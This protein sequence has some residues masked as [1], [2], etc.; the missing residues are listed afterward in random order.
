M[1]EEEV[2][3]VALDEGQVGRRFGRLRGRRGPWHSKGAEYGEGR[4]KVG[5]RSPALPAL[6][7]LPG[8]A[9]RLQANRRHLRCD[10]ELLRGHGRREE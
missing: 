10:D 7:T 8:D 3:R 5:V 4:S 6:P 9:T 1:A 2:P